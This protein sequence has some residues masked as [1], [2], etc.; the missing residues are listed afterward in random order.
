MGAHDIEGLVQPTLSLRIVT[1]DLSVRCQQSEIICISQIRWP[2]GVSI[3][4]VGP[5]YEGDGVST[6]PLAIHDSRQVLEVNGQSRVLDIA[7]FKFMNGVCEELL[8]VC[9]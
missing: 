2:V 9:E 6:A 3:D 5:L 1:R 4:I 7:L 8:G